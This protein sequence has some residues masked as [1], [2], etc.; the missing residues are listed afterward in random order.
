MKAD[1]SFASLKLCSHCR[2]K[3][4]NLTLS[5]REWR[6]V[7][8]GV[9]NQRDANAAKNLANW[10]GSSFPVTGRRDR[11]SLPMAAMVGKA[12]GVC[13]RGVWAPTKLEHQILNS[14]WYSMAKCQF[15]FLRVS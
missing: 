1:L 9:L 4:C 11:I 8:G 13:G 6:C 10:P 7:G 12:S 3:K 2:W 15:L 5:Q 14:G